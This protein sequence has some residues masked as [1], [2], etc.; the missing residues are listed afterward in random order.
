[1]SSSQADVGILRQDG[2][3]HDAILQDERTED[4]DAPKDGGRHGTRLDVYNA[5]EKANFI[6]ASSIL[7]TLST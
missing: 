6:G 7:S 2:E 1:M 4:E 3:A 5:L